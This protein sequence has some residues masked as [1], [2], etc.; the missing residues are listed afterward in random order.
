M[1]VNP[2]DIDQLKTTDEFRSRLGDVLQKFCRPPNSKKLLIVLNNVFDNNIISETLMA[3]ADAPVTLLVTSRARWDS[4]F[5]VPNRVT[6]VRLDDWSKFP[7]QSEILLKLIGGNPSS[8]LEEEAITHVAKRCHFLPLCLKIAASRK[9]DGGSWDGLLRND[10]F[11]EAVGEDRDQ[12][13][14][15]AFDIIGWSYELLSEPLRYAY[16]LCVVIESAQWIPTEVLQHLWNLP[17][18]HCS[19]SFACNEVLSELD[20]LALLD[21][22]HELQRVSIH[23]LL[24]EYLQG[25][26]I[27]VVESHQLLLAS[28][29]FTKTPASPMWVAMKSWDLQVE[30]VPIGEVVFLF[31]K[32]ISHAAGHLGSNLFRY[33]YCAGAKHQASFNSGDE[34][35]RDYCLEM[36]GALHS[37][38]T[39][40]VWVCTEF[41]NFCRQSGHIPNSTLI[42]PLR[43]LSAVHGMFGRFFQCKK[44]LEEA[45]MHPLDVLSKQYALRIK[46]DL[47]AANTQCGHFLEAA[48]QFDKLKPHLIG[49][50]ARCLAMYAMCL[51]KIDRIQ[52]ALPLLEN[53]NDPISQLNS[54]SIMASQGNI[55][56][57]WKLL[58]KIPSSHV[59][60]DLEISIQRGI[61]LRLQ[62][63]IK[64]STKC[65]ADALEKSK[66]LIGHLHPTTLSLRYELALVRI[67]DVGTHEV[68]KEI[69]DVLVELRNFVGE[70]SQQVLRAQLTKALCLWEQG[71]LIET[72]NILNTLLDQH[73]QSSGANGVETKNIQEVLGCLDQGFTISRVPRSWNFERPTKERISM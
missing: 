35:F 69:E 3:I 1:I 55:S 50:Y 40:A 14:L 5:T 59:N 31:P 37:I 39:N 65:L 34:T 45:I 47:A 22:D 27:I 54:V 2:G 16:S 25:D 19:D 18:G 32:V 11:K 13:N 63:N 9:R 52:E 33:M 20:K 42:I 66:L 71:N 26:P 15:P 38:D 43:R 17:P 48:A 53:S 6:H 12:D 72:R 73:T 70:N 24:L 30:Y 49:P 8:P 61:L 23:D 64:E 7:G 36:G 68:L 62:G 57:A 4:N 56:E 29:G 67:D 41:L 21:F 28:F 51:V 60:I 58:Q 44:F 46:I 10:K